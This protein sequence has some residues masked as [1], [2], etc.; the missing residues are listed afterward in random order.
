MR[1]PSPPLSI[2]YASFWLGA[3]GWEVFLTTPFDYRLL[4]ETNWKS[5][6]SAVHSLAY[7][8]SR[9]STLAFIVLFVHQQS[10]RTDAC[11]RTLVSTASMFSISVC[12]S[13]CALSWTLGVAAR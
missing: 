12:S 9:F 3:L 1:F 2:V 7:F 5:F 8:F 11:F 13:E 6:L 10:T 4:T